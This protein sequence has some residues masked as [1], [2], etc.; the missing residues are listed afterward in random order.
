VHSGYG[1]RILSRR[2]EDG[3]EVVY[4][5]VWTSPIKTTRSRLALYGSYMAMAALAGSLSGRPDVVFASSPPLPVAVAAAAVAARHRAP[6]VLDVRDLWPA[7]AVALGEL[8]NQ[9]IVGWTERL[10][11]WLY[12]RAT[13]ITAV[14]EPFCEYIAGRLGSRDKIHLLPNGTTARWV[15]G[16]QVDGDR[17]ALRLPQ[18]AFLWTFAGN[19]GAAQ[20]LDAALDAAALLGEGFRLLLVGDGPAREA[21]E[22]RARNMPGASVEFRDQV[23]PDTAV[24]YLRS[25]NALLVSLAPHPTLGGFVPSKLYDYCAVGRPVVLAATGESR[26]LVDAHA[27]AFSVP[28]ANPTA[29]ASAIRRLRDDPDLA[30]ELSERGHR[31]G[32]DNVRDRHVERLDRLLRGLL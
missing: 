13:A 25:S 7:A 10:E 30:Q 16:A 18:D 31:F 9:R 14:T 8:S 29:L 27:A 6:W 32:V 19:M 15:A 26:R 3:Y 2:S 21:L 24:R 12:H 4:V 23:D 1:G 5:W 20:G 17:D 28:P 11:T 22:R